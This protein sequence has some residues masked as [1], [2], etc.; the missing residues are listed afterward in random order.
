[1]N[2]GY[3]AYTVRLT[4]ALD[5][6]SWAMRDKKLK[7]AREYLADIKHCCAQLE[8]IVTPEATLPPGFSFI[9]RLNKYL[10]GK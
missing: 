5:R 4:R 10:G 9:R 2:I 8:S 1:M 3:T 7:D 6:F